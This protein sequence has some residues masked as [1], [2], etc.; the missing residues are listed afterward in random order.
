MKYKIGDK[1]IF[2]I[3]NVLKSGYMINNKTFLTDITLKE[4]DTANDDDI[5]N[6]LHNIGFRQGLE[7][8]F[9]YTKKLFLGSKG[10]YN[11][12]DLVEMFGDVDPQNILIKN[13]IREIID[14]MDSYDELI[15]KEITVGDVVV[16]DGGDIKFIVTKSD[17]CGDKSKCTLMAFDGS[18]WEGC[19][20]ENCTKTGYHADYFEKWL[21][22][23]EVCTKQKNDN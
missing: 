17:Y 7:K 13:S 4:I 6:E 14:K 19:D 5:K 11:T 21:K 22:E 2:E 15:E 1:F 10:G 16:V 12:E 20:K 3:T 9:E 23:M 8:G 18:A